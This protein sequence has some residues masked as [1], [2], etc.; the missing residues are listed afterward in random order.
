MLVVLEI[1]Q[2]ED[3]PLATACGSAGNQFYLHQW[4]IL[5]VAEKTQSLVV[6]KRTIESKPAPLSDNSITVLPVINE[7]GGTYQRASGE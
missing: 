3:K 6:Y 2:Q 5:I 4:R 1:L 7:M